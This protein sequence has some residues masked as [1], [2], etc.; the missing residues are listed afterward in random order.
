[1]QLPLLVSP[2][3]RPVAVQ[4]SDLQ[5][6]SLGGGVN[7][8]GTITASASTSP[9][10]VHLVVTGLSWASRPSAVYVYFDPRYPVIGTT[11]L[12]NG[13]M[14]HLGSDL[15]ARGLS[16]A[17]QSLDA[18]GLAAF[19]QANT[20]GVLVVPTTALPSN[21]FSK[22]VDLLTPWIRRGGTLVWV[23]ELIGGYTVNATVEPVAWNSTLNLQWAGEQRIFGSPLVGGAFPTGSIGTVRSAATGP[24]GLVY[25]LDDYGAESDAVTRM[26]GLSLGWVGSGIEN[27]SHPYVST[28]TSIAAVHV[29]NGT[30]VLLGDT[31]N[32]PS[33]SPGG[34]EGVSHDIAQ[35][36]ASGVAYTDYRLTDFLSQTYVVSGT[37]STV[38]WGVTLPSAVGAVSVFAFIDPCAE[39][40]LGQC[41]TG[42]FAFAQQSVAVA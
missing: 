30:V 9:V 7:V 8:T 10:G 3:W 12:M 17:V 13:L 26:G 35:I 2:V 18:P 16:S 25:N 41:F 40:N 20:S 23:G 33:L 4:L 37:G 31:M 1:M 32:G 34:L 14:D 42:P 19:L 15:R 22:S 27:L 36:L 29:G 6:V 5:A 38:R 21:V 28:K 11:F 24:L 39:A